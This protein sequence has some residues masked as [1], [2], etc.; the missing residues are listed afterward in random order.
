MPTEVEVEVDYKPRNWAQA[1]HDSVKRWIVLV[2]HRR[3]GKTTAILNHLQ[4]DA[5][6]VPKSQYAFIAPT[7]K[8]AKRIAWEILKDIARVVDDTE[9][10]ESE[11]IMKY[12]NGSRIFLAGSENIDALR[13]IPL[14][15]GG[16]D[17]SSQQPPNLFTEVISKCLADHLGYWIWS[18]TPKGKNN[19]YKTYQIGLKNPDQYTVVF[20]TIDDSLKDEKG[21]TIENLRKALEDDRK[22]VKLGEMT[23]E[24]FDQEWYCSF[25]AA[26]KGAYYAKEISL[27]RK[28]GRIRLVPYERL[29]PVH[30]VTDLGNGKN[31]ATGFYQKL[32]TE[33]RMIDFWQGDNTDG[34]PEL[35]VVLQ[36]KGY[37]YGKHFAPHDIRAVEQ[38]TGKT[39]LETA[40]KL[41]IEFDVVPDIGIDNGIKAGQLMFSRLW[42][43]EK[44]CEYW[45]DAMANYQQEWDES[46][47]MFKESPYHNWASHPADVHRYSAVVEDKMRN[48]KRV[49][50]RQKPFVASSP[51]QGG[52]RHKEDSV[53][54]L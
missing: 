39:K 2:L 41:G 16:Q 10:N 3:A 54:E 15:G 19:F 22:L 17:E 46:K 12:G 40:K 50:Y 49:K 24:E 6:N 27:A 31:L 1:F 20:K 48:E 18:G 25:E 52:Q 26:I 45:L 53:I 30:T 7:Y 32:G 5:L 43:D 36:N 42:V 14:W 29:L 35:A 4:R 38:G 28:D 37:R 13:G 34:L 51:Y 44:K 33:I 23:Q 47:G 11:L 9:P 21:E 8:Q